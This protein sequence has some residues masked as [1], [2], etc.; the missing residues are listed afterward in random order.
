MDHQ[1]TT[2]AVADMLY[3]RSIVAAVL[4]VVCCAGTASAQTYAVRKPRRH[5]IT[6]SADWLNTQPLHFLEHPLQDLV[7]RDVAAA[8]FEA[9]EYRTRDEQIRIDVVEFRRR[10]R[11]AG[12]TL[13]PF[14]MNV[15]PALAVRGSV[16]DLP[17]ITVAF[18]GI[19]APAGYTLTGGRAYDL[20]AAV[21]VADRSPGWGLG[22]H[23][24]VGG[25]IGRIRS[26]LGDGNRYFGEAGGG[27]SSGPLGVELAVK[28]AW[29]RLSEPV[30]H[31]FFTVPIALRGTLTF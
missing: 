1:L 16:E 12:I 20:A 19:G 30:D 10:G 27:L 4:A 13:Y 24:F 6:V 8:Q 14:G 9:Y 2:R 17:V 26:D 31:E 25:G 5:F 29:N 22:S 11:G 18:S 15:G 21:Y 3:R 23:A 28:F 7:G